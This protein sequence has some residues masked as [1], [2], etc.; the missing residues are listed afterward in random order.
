M[1]TVELG[2]NRFIGCRAIVGYAGA[3]LLAVETNPLR[4]SLRIPDTKPAS[5]YRVE[6]VEGKMVSGE[7]ITIIS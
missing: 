7:G 6:I 2:S 4:L 1:T 3:D 5:G